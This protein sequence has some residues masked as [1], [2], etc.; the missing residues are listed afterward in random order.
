MATIYFSAPMSTGMIEQTK[1]AA[2]LAT[3]TALLRTYGTSPTELNAATQLERLAEAVS[4]L[5]REHP[6][7]VENVSAIAQ[8]CAAYTRVAMERHSHAK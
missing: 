4:R 3:Y 2:R 6:D 5:T 7:I 8:D 1:V